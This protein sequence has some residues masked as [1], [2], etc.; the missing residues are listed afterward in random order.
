MSSKLQCKTSPVRLF[1]MK[2]A[3][4][5]YERLANSVFVLGIVS[6]GSAVDRVDVSYMLDIGVWNNW[7]GPIHPP[8]TAHKR[9][10]TSL[11]ALKRQYVQ[12][13]SKKIPPCGFLTFFPKQM[14]IFYQ[15]LHTY[16]TFIST[17]GCKSLFKYLQLWRS[18]A[19]LSATTQRIFTFHWK[20]KFKFAYWANDVTVDVMSYPT[21]LLTL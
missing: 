11:S 20:F 1:Q 16:Y 17:L 6:S 5:E 8:C 10:N 3:E 21:C 15:F 19:I 4:Y 9:T 12:C 13:E 14:G 18:Y 7:I 2:G